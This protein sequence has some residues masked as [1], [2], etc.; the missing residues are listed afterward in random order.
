MVV[1]GTFIEVGAE[2]V[3]PAS[4]AVRRVLRNGQDTAAMRRMLEEALRQA[5]DTLSR[6]APGRAG[7]GQEKLAAVASG[8]VNV[9]M[10]GHAEQV[11]FVR[12]FWERRPPAIGGYRRHELQAVGSRA[13]M[14]E[15]ARWI[16]VS[17]AANKVEE[18]DG[19]F[20]DL[21][22]SR[23]IRAVCYPKPYSANYEFCGRLA[24]AWL[25][26]DEK[27]MARDG[28]FRRLEYPTVLTGAVAAVGAIIGWT[29]IEVLRVAGSVGTVT[30]AVAIGVGLFARRSNSGVVVN[31]RAEYVDLRA[32]LEQISAFLVDVSDTRVDSAE[33]PA[34][35]DD[36]ETRR[37]LSLLLGNLQQRLLPEAQARASLLAS[38]LRRVSDQL[39]LFQEGRLS[40]DSLNLQ[41]AMLDLRRALEDV[42]EKRQ[43]LVPA[44]AA[45]TDSQ[46]A[47]GDMP[48]ISGLAEQP[49]AL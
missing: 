46:V 41:A 22:A 35:G 12:A 30:V 11:S 38:H 8:A 47:A 26:Q 36:E 33:G 17:A 6:S 39:R 19:R 4:R 15:L 3:G 24:D 23:F 21:A 31:S 42:A 28:T 1:A 7:L 49:E 29:G 9:G 48:Q 2:F 16:Q 32:L 43:I 44:G 27:A 37:R 25:S 5:E 10:T 34:A 20:A 45:R 13:A 18:V 40:F 14:A